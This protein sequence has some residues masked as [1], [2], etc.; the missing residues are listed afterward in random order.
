MNDLIDL[1]EWNRFAD[2]RKTL[3]EALTILNNRHREAVGNA[4]AELSIATAE[5]DDF[6]RQVETMRVAI[7]EAYALVKD[8]SG[9]CADKCILLHP[10]DDNK[11]AFNDVWE[12]SEAA[13]EKLKP[14]ITTP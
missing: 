8:A 5:R 12:W 10:D 14:F 1:M 11:G 4:E 3:L 13:L 2:E 6:R 7:K 9:H